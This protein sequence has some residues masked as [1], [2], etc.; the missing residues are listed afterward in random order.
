MYEFFL[1]F[2]F[3][4]YFLDTIVDPIFSLLND[5]L[6]FKFIK[7]KARIFYASILKILKIDSNKTEQLIRLHY[8]EFLNSKISRAETN[9]SCSN[10]IFNKSEF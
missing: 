4:L 10:N 1:S 9:Y 7:H 3:L 6:L 8:L 2:L 5:E